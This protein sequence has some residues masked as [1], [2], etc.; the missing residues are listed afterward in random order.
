MSS[1]SD[2]FTVA[3]KRALRLSEIEAI[4]DNS[5]TIGATHLMLALARQRSTIAAQ[6]FRS[7]GVEPEQVTRALVRA[8]DFSGFGSFR[9]TL[10]APDTEGA[11]RAAVEAAR[12][13]RSTQIDTGHLLLGVLAVENGIV[14]Q[15]FRGLRV[16]LSYL[17]RRTAR[18]I[19][20]TDGKEH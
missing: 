13:M 12:L 7:V 9:R 3:A 2:H 16:D 1:T 15:V 11:M 5:D 4:R 18:L 17:R 6:A 19:V 14:T 10:L 20:E 8:L